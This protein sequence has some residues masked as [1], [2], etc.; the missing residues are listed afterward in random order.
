MREGHEATD[1]VRRIVVAVD[2]AAE[3]TAAL[4]WA[5]ETATLHDA[6]VEIVGAWTFPVVSYERMAATPLNP[7][8]FEDVARSAIEKSIAP[9]AATTVTDVK[10]TV[11]FGSPAAVI[12]GAAQHAQRVVL[13]SRGLGPFAGWV[14]GSV[15]R[16]VAQHAPCPVGRHADGSL[17]GVSISPASRQALMS[18]A[19]TRTGSIVTTTRDWPGGSCSRRSAPYFAPTLSANT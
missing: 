2:G 9:A 15:S 4:Q 13:G 18:T 16:Q 5:Y 11:A 12:L 17:T 3:A 1:P 6:S 7:A 19:S 14:L 10:R 8:P